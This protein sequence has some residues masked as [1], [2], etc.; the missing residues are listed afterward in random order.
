MSFHHLLRPWLLSQCVPHHSDGVLPIWRVSQSLSQCHTPEAARSPASVTAECLL[1][2][3]GNIIRVGFLGCI[4]LP[5][6]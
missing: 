6:L 1:N 2:I 5:S 3:V 4:H